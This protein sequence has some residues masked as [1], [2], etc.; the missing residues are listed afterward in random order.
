MT[1]ESGPEGPPS[2]TAGQRTFGAGLL[3][4]AALVE[5]IGWPALPDLAAAP[6][7]GWAGRWPC[8]RCSDWGSLVEHEPPAVEVAGGRALR[9]LDCGGE[10]TADGLLAE[11]RRTLAGLAALAAVASLEEVAA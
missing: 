7:E 1:R 2:T 5:R 3:A 6:F 11:L 8:P 9:C 4:C 10:P